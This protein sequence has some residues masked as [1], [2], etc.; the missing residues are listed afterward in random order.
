M[1]TSNLKERI[2]KF[3][4]CNAIISLEQK[5]CKKKKKE[6][7][8]HDCKDQLLINNI[9]IENCRLKQKNLS[10]VWINYKTFDSLSHEWILNVINISKVSSVIITFLKYNIKRWHTNLRLIH[11]KGMLT[12][13]NMNINNEIF[14]GHPRSP[15]LFCVALTPLSIVL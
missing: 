5:G 8:N 15:L 4:D 13:N 6:K 1:I 11:E 9:I 3:K 14:Q 12:T 2:V 10:M 7:K